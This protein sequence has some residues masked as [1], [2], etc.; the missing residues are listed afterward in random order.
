MTEMGRLG[1]LF[2]C[3]RHTQ[4]TRRSARSGG[5]PVRR[6]FLIHPRQTA[7]GKL[8]PGYSV[9]TQQLKRIAQLERDLPY[10]IR[11]DASQLR[12]LI[13]FRFVR[14]FISLEIEG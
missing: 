10:V 2:I 6:V 8:V 4:S 12:L 9:K 11:N 13:E 3:S 14:Y 7:N 1:H 5:H